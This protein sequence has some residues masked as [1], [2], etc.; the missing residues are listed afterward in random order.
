MLAETA[1]V[2]GDFETAR[3]EAEAAATAFARQRRSPWTALARYAALRAAF[4]EH[5]PSAERQKAARRA[6]TALGS[7]GWTVAA[8]DAHLLAARIALALGETAAARRALEHVRVGPREPVD[9]RVRAKHASALLALADGKRPRAYA[10]A[11]GRRAPARRLPRRARRDRASRAGRRAGS[12]SSPRSG[13]G[14]RS[15]TPS[16]RACW[17]GWRSAGPAPCGLRPVRP[18]DNEELAA[19]LAELRRIVA[20]VQEGAFAGRDV[21]DLRRRQATLEDSVRQR[22]RRAPGGIRAAAEARAPAEMEALLGERALI[23]YL[24][25]EGRLHAVTVSDGQ[26][27]LHALGGC[28]GSA[29]GARR[30]PVRAAPARTEQHSSGLAGRG[31]RGREPCG[32]QTGRA[33]RPAP[34]RGDRRAAA[35]P[36]PHRRAA[37]DAVVDRAEPGRAPARRRAVRGRLGRSR[38]ACRPCPAQACDGCGRAWTAVR[39][40]RGATRWARCTG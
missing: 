30:A 12:R 7:A 26:T 11:P 5:G 19:E 29:R 34:G 25:V 24:E 40:P 8:L 36:R 18:P 3:T 1:L 37:R 13:F 14:W 31:L 33:A 4:L 22:T 20:D 38:G 27:R 6:A 23:A 10:D 21:R 17:P 2:G 28:R 35:G 16:R 15:R 32:G 39:R 9:L